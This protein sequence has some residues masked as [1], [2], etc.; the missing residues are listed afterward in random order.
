[1]GSIVLFVVFVPLDCKRVGDIPAAWLR[2]PFIALWS[3]KNHAQ[4][5]CS[6]IHAAEKSSNKEYLV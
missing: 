6:H 3:L 4:N 5:Y 2:G 1:V